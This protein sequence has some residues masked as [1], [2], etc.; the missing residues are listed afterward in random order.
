MALQFKVWIDDQSVV[1]TKD[2]ED[3]D[4]YTYLALI[5]LT[6]PLNSTDHIEVIAS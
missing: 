6:V 5:G 1:V 2:A 4:I 3:H